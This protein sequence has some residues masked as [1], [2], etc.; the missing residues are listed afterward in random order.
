MNYHKG[1][2]VPKNL[3]QGPN[4]K[5]ANELKAVIEKYK[6]GPFVAIWHF[7]GDRPDNF[8][9]MLI[10]QPTKA[11]AD[12]AWQGLRNFISALITSGKIKD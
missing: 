11:W 6:V 10:G 2:Y 8:R 3:A 1:M 5:F 9:R 7:P 4:N 12:A